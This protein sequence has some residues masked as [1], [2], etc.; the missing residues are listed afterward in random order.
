M[1]VPEA[2]LARFAAHMKD[3]G[4]HVAGESRVPGVALPADEAEADLI[5]PLDERRVGLN[6]ATEEPEAPNQVADLSS[7]PDT[8]ITP[9]F[10]L[11]CIRISEELRHVLW[12]VGFQVQLSRFN[13]AFQKSAAAHHVIHNATHQR[14]PATSKRK[15][16]DEYRLEQTITP[17]PY[18]AWLRLP[19]GVDRSKRPTDGTPDRLVIRS[20]NISI[21]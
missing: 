21:N 11:R 5:V 20:T 7:T 17:A 14:E 10:S 16:D 6:H 9:Y 2:D 3:D 15:T 18:P 13:V 4:C 19:T 1:P 8:Q 12:Q